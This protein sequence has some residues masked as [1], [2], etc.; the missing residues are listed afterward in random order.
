MNFLA[1]LVV[2]V[3]ERVRPLPA[4]TLVE[5]PLGA[6]A[7]WLEH[8]VNAGERRHGALAWWL[9]AG[10]LAG[11]SAVIGLLLDHLSPLLGGLWTVLL[12]YWA[13]GCA[14][15]YDAFAE[16]LLAMRLGDLEQAQARLAEWRREPVDQIDSARLAR[17]AVDTLLL[18]AHRR[19]FGVLVGFVLLPGP[20]GAVLYR[21]AAYL[22]DAW[23]PDTADAAGFGEYAAKAFAR[24]DWLP[25]RLTA[26]GFAVVGNFEDALF[27]WRTAAERRRAGSPDDASLIVLECAAGAL[28]QRPERAAESGDVDAEGY[29]V[30]CVDDAEFMQSASGLVGRLLLLWLLLLLLTGLAAAVG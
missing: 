4:R 17:V 14:S 28:G 21:V 6:L 23:R 24:L 16:I 3:L 15:D 27:A 9:A 7:S 25:A 18:A 8:R 26:L 29:C 10:G 11:A 12:L 22:A 30:N 13:M 19:L 20:S 1:L 2:L 5:E